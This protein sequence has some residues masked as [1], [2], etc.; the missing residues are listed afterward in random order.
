MFLLAL[1]T[2][3]AVHGVAPTLFTLVVTAIEYA[4]WGI[5]LLLLAGAGKE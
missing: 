1:L 5:I 2:H 3:W 4:L